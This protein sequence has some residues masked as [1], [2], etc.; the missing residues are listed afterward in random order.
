MKAL[1]DLKNLLNQQRRK[2]HGRLIEHEKLRLAHERSSHG[3]HLLLAAGERTADLRTALFE[4]REQLIDMLQIFVKLAVRT[5]VCAHF[6]IFFNCHSRKNAA[7]FGALNKAGL[8]DLV[9]SHAR[10]VVVH[11]LNLAASGLE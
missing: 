3:Q 10:D 5:R 1:D 2:A 11:E 6:Q 9:G 7:A 4:A 8:D